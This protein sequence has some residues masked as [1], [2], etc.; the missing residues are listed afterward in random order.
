MLTNLC[1]E[2]HNWFVREKHHGTYEIIG[3]VLTVPF[4]QPG[5]YYRIIGS[6]FNDGVKQYGVHDLSD[7]VFEGS[8][9]ALAIPKE[10]VELSNDIDDWI[11]KYKDVQNSPYSSESSTWYSYTKNTG[12][13]EAD[14][15]TWKGVFASQ[16]NR[17]RKI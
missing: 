7:E 15:T 6:I 16:L 11:A 13:G 3:G 8:I 5:Q 14:K 9:W 10:V 17:W 2:L 12:S 1:Q 4:L